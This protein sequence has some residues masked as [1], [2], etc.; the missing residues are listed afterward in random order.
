MKN[1]PNENAIESLAGDL[2]HEIRQAPVLLI[3]MT[4][5][6]FYGTFQ[7]IYSEMEDYI[8]PI[9]R[10]SKFKSFQWYKQPSLKVSKNNC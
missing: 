1:I 6:D 5:G 2:I 7:L 8:T 9:S 10:Y 3:R 4:K